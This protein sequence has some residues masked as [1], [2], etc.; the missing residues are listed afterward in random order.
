MM[1]G[2][3]G[4]RIFPLVLAAA[5][6]PAMAA[7]AP[8]T[9]WGKPGVSEAQYRADALDCA[10]QGYDLDIADTDDA[11]AFVRGSRELD[12]ATQSAGTAAPGANPVETSVIIANQQEQIRRGIDPERRMARIHAL[13]EKTV[14]RCLTARGYARFALTEAQRRQLR[15]LAAG[16][17]G[18]RAYLFALASDPAILAHQQVP[19]DRN[20]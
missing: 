19:A 3:H 16:S 15:K 5:A 13:M 12:D 20:P 10:R 17:A 18:R 14:A 1:T 6:L 9:S 2:S 7:P 4:R 11:K 8:Q